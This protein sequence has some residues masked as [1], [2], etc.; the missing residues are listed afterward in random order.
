MKGSILIVGAGV[1]GVFTAIELAKRDFTVTLLESGKIPN[2]KA[3]S[4]DI[5]KVVRVEYGSDREYFKM[6]EV[7]MNQWKNWNNILNEDV[8]HEVGFLMLS[9]STISTK[10]NTYEAHSLNMLLSEGYNVERLN[11]ADIINRF[12][13]I[14]EGLYQEAMYNPKGGF[15]RSGRAIELLANYAKRIGVRIVEQTIASTLIIEKGEIKGIKDHRG[16]KYYADQVVVSAGA[17]TPYLL[18]ELQPYFNI[19]GHPIFWLQP[20]QPKLFSADKLPVFMADIAHTGYYGFPYNKHEGIVKISKH[21]SGLSQ[22]PDHDRVV[23]EQETADLR[24]FVKKSFP[25]LKDAHLKYTRK[26]LYT[27]TLDGHYWIDKH[28]TVKGLIVSTGGSGHG[29]KMGPELGRITADVVEGIAHGYSNRY[30]WRHISIDK[31]RKEE[32]RLID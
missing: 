14:A 6:A 24:T 10:D 2:P 12:P 19:T 31:I 17:H 8:Y 16:Q 20:D 21:A 27:D 7:S 29:M 1:F 28:P 26:C 25:I 18:P 11:S 22:H 15:V 32:A 30:D 13:S 23:T 5:S 9:S 4:T 3:A